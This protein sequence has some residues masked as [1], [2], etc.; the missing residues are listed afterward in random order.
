MSA[1]I[2]IDEALYK[3]LLRAGKELVAS[4]NCVSGYCGCGIV[5]FD[6]SNLKGEI[7]AMQH[8]IDNA[9]LR[10]PLVTL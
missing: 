6:G 3:A 8:A 1:K 2:E 10:G 7:N 5:E 9:E 4:A